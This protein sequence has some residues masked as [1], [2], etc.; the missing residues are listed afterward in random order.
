MHQAKMIK[1]IHHAKWSVHNF[2]YVIKVVILK[3]VTQTDKTYPRKFR[4]RVDTIF[5]SRGMSSKC[6]LG[7]QR[8][9]TSSVTGP[10]PPHIYGRDYLS[11]ITS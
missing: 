8:Q 11:D 7:S 5:I 9:I 2:L 1:F 4:F 10:G 6:Q 3:V